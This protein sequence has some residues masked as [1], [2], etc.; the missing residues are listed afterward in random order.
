MSSSASIDEQAIL[1][2]VGSQS[3]ERGRSYW[4][5][6]AITRGRLQDGLLKAH[7]EG[8]YDNEY[9]VEA[10]VKNG[11]IVDADCSC[12]VGDG[13][14]CK[15]V[16]ALLLT[17]LHRPEA[18]P[19]V[20][21]LERAL[22]QRSKPELI[23][24][25]RQMLRVQPD[26]ESLLELPLPAA[27]AAGAPLD[28]AKFRAQAEAAFRLH[29]RDWDVIPQAVDHLEATYAVG[30]D[31]T[32]QGQVVNA[33]AI[34]HAVL[35]VG[36]EHFADYQDD[37][38]SLTGVVQALVVRLGKV[39][40]TLDEGHSEREVVLR[41]LLDTYQR[42]LSLGGLCLAD[43]VPDLFFDL[44]SPEERATLAKW[45]R[46]AI[47]SA[48][49]EWTRSGLGAL[50][51][52]LE[53][54]QLDDEGYLA[55]CRSTG[56]TGDLVDRLL[57]LGR[58]EEARA[59]AETAEDYHLLQFAALF[60]DYGYDDL[61]EELVRVRART[62]HDSRL[63]E[64]LKTRCLARGDVDEALKLARE[65]FEL[66]PQLD[67]YHALR[68]LAQR[69]NLWETLRPELHAFL[70]TRQ[71]WLFLKVLLEEGNIEAALQAVTAPTDSSRGFFGYGSEL[72]LEVAQAAE[73]NFPREALRLYQQGAERQIS[74]RNRGAY[75]EAS[76]M[77]CKVRDL[78]VRLNEGPKWER[79]IAG[80]RATH[81]TL[82]ALREELDDAGL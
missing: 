69:A 1:A 41:L 51:L 9:R 78:Y 47:P 63:K 12:P 21:A 52:D 31:F 46:E 65:V 76:R 82:R 58:I 79:Y 30:D 32:R 20:E 34:Y 2:R 60:T 38:G 44:T 50:L 35:E 74:G 70:E 26:L 15:H 53:A 37:Q 7:C 80:L 57:S 64:W 43:D 33:S 29:G 16:A 22:E 10:R 27:E 62:S 39:L 19:E 28:P 75:A 48:R 24:L 54:D 23:A 59:A 81:R 71:R 3:M 14:Y 66:R 6:G 73:E 68:E 49:R 42:D 77:L 67:G 8:S 25:I 61:A 40:S 17:W 72:T 45:I 55:V 5:S 13:G 18:F 11:Q 56:R 4:K 36:L